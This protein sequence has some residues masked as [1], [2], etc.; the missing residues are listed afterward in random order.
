[1]DRQSEAI[2]NPKFGDPTSSRFKPMAEQKFESLQKDKITLTGEWTSFEGAEKAKKAHKEGVVHKAE[3]PSEQHQ[4]SRVDDSVRK[5]AEV[6]G[7]KVEDDEPVVATENNQE[8][9]AVAEIDDKEDTTK[10]QEVTGGSEEPQPTP[11]KTLA[12]AGR[13]P[14]NTEVP[15]E[16]LTLKPRDEVLNPT[17]KRSEEV[18]QRDEWALPDEKGRK[19]LVVNA[20]TGDIVDAVDEGNSNGYKDKDKDKDE[21]SEA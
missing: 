17:A 9:G 18:S 8:P 2:T 11:K 15:S 13:N 3:P 16:G 4:S 20:S 5:L 10:K 12:K 1:M 6:H 14:Y 21:N 7:K 19:K